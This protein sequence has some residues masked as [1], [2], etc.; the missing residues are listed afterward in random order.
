MTPNRTSNFVGLVGF[1]A[2]IAS[3][4]VGIK[5]PA[6]AQTNTDRG[7]VSIGGGVGNDAT[8]QTFNLTINRRAEK[9]SGTPQAELLA[10]MQK[11]ISTLIESGKVQMS[12]SA[13]IELADGLSEI[14]QKAPLTKY[15]IS[16]EQF[17]VPVKKGYL[18]FNGDHT[19]GLSYIQNHVATILL[20]GVRRRMNPG[21]ILKFKQ[22]DKQCR[23]VFNGA[24]KDMMAGDFTVLCN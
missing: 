13:S 12:N 2:I 24:S 16:T 11:L 19:L 22:N 4:F 1:A 18:M 23:L 5:S 6:L 21:D 20:D 14:A 7:S 3:L 17:T 15:V 8:I 10:S 9:L